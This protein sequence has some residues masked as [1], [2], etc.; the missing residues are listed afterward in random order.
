MNST[1]EDL[2]REQART[3]IVIFIIDFL[4]EKGHSDNV[5]Y[6]LLDMIDQKVLD[7]LIDEVVKVYKK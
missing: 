5:I 1:I 6:D 3:N 4:K 2:Y 7:D